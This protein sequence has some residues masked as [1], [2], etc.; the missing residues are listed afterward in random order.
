M[1]HLKSLHMECL[2][3]TEE[4]SHELDQVKRINE[5]L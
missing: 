4:L 5:Q 1:E 2:E 3:T